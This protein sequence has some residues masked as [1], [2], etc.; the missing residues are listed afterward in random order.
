MSGANPS[1]RLSKRSRASD[2]AQHQVAHT[3]EIP[4]K[5]RRFSR[6]K[7]DDGKG[8]ELTAPTVSQESTSNYCNDDGVHSTA[9]DKIDESS[10]VPWSSSQLVA[11]R[12][13]DIDP[14][15]TTDEE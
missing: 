15:F 14:V 6:D 5:R 7:K 1:S 13:I 9:V 2:A 8:L 12:Y 10:R 11:G 3:D 4:V